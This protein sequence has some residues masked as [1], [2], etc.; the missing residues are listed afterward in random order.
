M[1]YSSFRSLLRTTC[2]STEFPALIK[3][4]ETKKQKLTNNVPANEPP[5]TCAKTIRT[6]VQ[7]DG[8]IAESDS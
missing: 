6:T 5:D 7:P 8:T 2:A 1:E 4:I 3:Q